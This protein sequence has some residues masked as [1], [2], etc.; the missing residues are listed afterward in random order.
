[1]F[2]LHGVE[3]ECLSVA[4]RATATVNI[5]GS[6]K[7]CLYTQPSSLPATGGREGESSPGSTLF[8]YNLIGFRVFVSHVEV[9]MT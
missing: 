7:S 4:L 8:L 6:K 2:R 3:F 9:D 5:R 1:M